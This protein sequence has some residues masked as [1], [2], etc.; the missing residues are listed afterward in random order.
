VKI[1]E[2][3]SGFEALR[4]L[5]REPFDLIVTD[6]NM[7]DINGLELVSFAKSN[8]AYRSIPLIIVST[9][10]AERDRAR[11]LELGADAYLVKPF[12]AE[13]LR[14]VVVDLLSRGM[15]SE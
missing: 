2:A 4:C 1:T 6:I 10:G 12:D 3:S 11:G 14:E 15:R 9:E 8:D 13:N 5:P 7:P